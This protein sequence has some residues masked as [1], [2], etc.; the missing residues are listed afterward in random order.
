MVVGHP[1]DDPSPDDERALGD[2]TLERLVAPYVDEGGGK[3]EVAILGR[4]ALNERG[5]RAVREKDFIYYSPALKEDASAGFVMRHVGLVN[6]PAQAGLPAL[7]DLIVLSDSFR[8]ALYDKAPEDQAWVFAASDYDIKQL[9]RASAVVDG[10]SGNPHTAAVPDDLAKGACHLPHHRPDGTVVWRGV[11]AAAGALAGSRGGVAISDDMKARARAHLAKHYKE[12]QRKL[13]IEVKEGDMP[14]DTLLFD[15]ESLGQLKTIVQEAVVAGV[16]PFLEKVSA[17]V[18]A[19]TGKAEPN[20]G[21]ED[22]DKLAEVKRENAELRDR[23]GGLDSE[24]KAQ[25]FL[26]EMIEKGCPKATAVNLADV[27]RENPGTEKAIRK[28]AESY[29]ADH[30]LLGG[31]HLSLTDEERQAGAKDFEAGQKAARSTK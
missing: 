15:E 14:M 29:A 9:V 30:K 22:E 21:T 17:L 8:L 16:A 13:D 3:H 11:A 2:V 6:D 27:V 18:E 28:V 20:E 31:I 24:V 26:S 10:I 1:E 23:L 7:Q 12:F 5:K 4:L 19:A 25:K